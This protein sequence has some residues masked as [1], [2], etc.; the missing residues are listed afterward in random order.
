[1]DGAWHTCERKTVDIGTPDRDCGGAQCERLDDVGA[2]AHAGVEHDRRIALGRVAADGVDDTGQPV[3]RC[4]PAV[5]LP[6]AVVGAVDAVDTPVERADGIV[7]VADALEHQGQVGERAQPGQ[8][9]PGQRI[10]ERADPGEDGRGHVGVGSGQRLED[11]VG[12]VVGQRLAAQLREVAAGQVARAPAGHPG[13]EGD[14]DRVVAGRLR[15]A[16]QA[17]REVAVLGRVQLEPGWRVAGGG[18]DVLERVAHQRGPDERDAGRG[19]D[20]GAVHVAVLVGCHQ[21][22]HTDGCHHQ[23]T[24]Q[25]GAEQVDRQVP[26]GTGAQHPRHQRPALEG[27]GVAALGRLGAA[28][29]RDIG[30]QLGRERGQGVGLEL[31]VGERVR[32]KI[33]AQSAEVELELVV[34]ETH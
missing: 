27:L 14:H 22:E 8:V 3:Q 24:G 15:A 33:A 9:V 7:W 23:R 18:R 32:R 17:G 1:M 5:G 31:G 26:L 4:S 19:R 29:T 12:G 20:L 11:R 2:G 28:T 6:A 21:T 34:T 10:A 25:V 13:V 16:D 30:A